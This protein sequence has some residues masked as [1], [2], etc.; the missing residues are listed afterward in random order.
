MIL[1]NFQLNYRKYLAIYFMDHSL[2][3]LLL[4]NNA[5]TNQ[6]Q[7]LKIKNMR[8]LS[9]EKINEIIEHIKEMCYNQCYMLS[10]QSD[11]PGEPFLKREI[12]PRNPVV[13]SKTNID[14]IYNL[15]LSL[16]HK[17]YGTS[18][19]HVNNFQYQLSDYNSNSSIEYIDILSICI[20]KVEFVKAEIYLGL[21]N[22]IENEVTAEIVSD[23]LSLSRK[24]LDE[25]MK[26]VAA[27]L[28]CASLEDTLKR[29][30][31]SNDL[32][33]DKKSMA[34]VVNALKSQRLI[35][36]AQGEML[37][38]YTQIRNKAFHA[39]WDGIEKPDISAIIGFTEQFILQHFS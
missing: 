4:L 11:K 15:T 19:E 21:L 23:F 17:I 32:D 16:L 10:G 12:P 2:L 30:A 35:S 18:N 26:Q 39:Q 22:T 28:C 31:K 25:D 38:G 7:K 9:E 29:F 33:V 8:R 1:P 34:E 14:V 20:A 6:D 36:S 27:V 13:V 37:K 3:N 24:S 5:L